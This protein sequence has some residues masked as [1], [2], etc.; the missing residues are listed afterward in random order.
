MRI[1]LLF[2][3]FMTERIHHLIGNFSIFYIF[4][5]EISK[6]NKDP[7]IMLAASL[8]IRDS[9]GHVRPSLE[10]EPA[11]EMTSVALCTRRSAHR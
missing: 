9:H 11:I 1:A 3:F 5:S 8:D 10:H 4:H 7:G 6:E 2:I